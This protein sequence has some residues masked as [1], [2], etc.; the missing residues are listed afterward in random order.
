MTDQESEKRRRTRGNEAPMIIW[1]RDVA[2]FFR[3]LF[4]A[5]GRRKKRG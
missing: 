1:P 4:S 2:R 3:Q 5:F